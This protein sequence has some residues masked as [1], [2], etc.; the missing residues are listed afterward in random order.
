MRTTLHLPRVARTRGFTLIELLVAI[1]I[2]S[3]IA[4]LSWRGI[5]GMVRSQQITR[6]R[7]DQLVVI[8][9]ALAQ[10]QADLDSI[11]AV[12]STQPISWDGQV[13]RITRRVAQQPDQG[14]VVVAWARRTASNGG[15]Q[16]LRWQSPPVN[17]RAAW[18]TAWQTAAQWARTP[19]SSEAQRETQLFPLADWQLY[20]FVGGAWANAQSSTGGS[21]AEQ[22]LDGLSA[23]AAA[24]PEGVRLQITLPEGGA[25][26]GAITQDWVNP[27]LGGNKS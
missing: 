2:M 1:T 6:E 25:I 9:N 27:A 26:T 11:Q 20:Y 8:Q 17:T 4:L 12:D 23:A 16:W 22:T 14:V 13:L 21:F 10:W 7:S 5:D 3:L 15:Q 19:S 24:V 18:N